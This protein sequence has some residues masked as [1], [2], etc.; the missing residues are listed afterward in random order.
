MKL[1]ETEYNT[2]L[3]IKELENSKKIKVI[4]PIGEKYPEAETCKTE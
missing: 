2:D 3:K 1:W 4:I